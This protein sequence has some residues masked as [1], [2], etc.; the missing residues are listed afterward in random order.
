MMKNVDKYFC[1]SFSNFYI[2][3]FSTKLMMKDFYEHF[4]IFFF[5]QNYLFDTDFLNNIIIIRSGT[6][7][8]VVIGLI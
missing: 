8:I 1:F 7:L 5:F 6:D 4:L 3:C 2:A